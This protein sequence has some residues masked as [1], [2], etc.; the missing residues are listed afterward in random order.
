MTGNEEDSRRTAA[1]AV[2][3]NGGLVTGRSV[4]REEHQQEQSPHPP[5]APKSSEQRDV[6]SMASAPGLQQ[7]KPNSAFPP[8]FPVKRI[9][10]ITGC[11]HFALP[12]LL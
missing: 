10:A 11:P 2:A 3:E 5:P 1:Q 9:T 4:I 12:K 7:G 6:M 8:Y